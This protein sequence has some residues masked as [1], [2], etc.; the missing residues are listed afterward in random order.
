MRL[1]A[2]P[3]RQEMYS[4][5]AAVSTVAQLH[6]GSAWHAIPWT[7]SAFILAQEARPGTATTGKIKRSMHVFNGSGIVQT[8]TL[9]GRAHILPDLNRVLFQDK[10]K[11]NAIISG[12]LCVGSGVWS[13]DH[14]HRCVAI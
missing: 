1:A 2:C 7:V 6:Y 10:K 14:C 5:N 11:R 9:A 4:I 13:I 12:A 3:A 8:D